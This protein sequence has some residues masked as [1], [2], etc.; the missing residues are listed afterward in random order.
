[1][2]RHGVADTVLAGATTTTR[3]VLHAYSGALDL[4]DPWTR[5]SG[6]FLVETADHRSFLFADC[7]VNRDPDAGALAEIALETAQS[8]RRIFGWEPR[9]A[10]LSF[11]THGSAEHPLVDKV[12]RA[13]AI[14]RE[15]EPALL[16]DGELQ[17]DAAVDLTVAHHKLDPIG[18]VAGQANVLVFPDLNAGN[19]AYK[20]VRALGHARAVGVILQGFSSPVSDL[21]RGATVAEIVATATV[22][23]ALVDKPI[24]VS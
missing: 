2:V 10:M 19:I 16:I 6:F 21:S 8:A 7:A 5:P 22:L 4:A 11:S 17:A 12:R 14:A 18:P 20:L 1:M 15:R 23:G 3:D 13:T 9:V 24:G